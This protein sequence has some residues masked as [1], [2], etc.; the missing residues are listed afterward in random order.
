MAVLKRI[1]KVSFT[2]N[3]NIESTFTKYNSYVKIYNIAKENNIKIIPFDIYNFLKLHKEIEI[4]FDGMDISISFILNKIKDKYVIKV[5]K[6]Q[7]IQRQRF[8]LAYAFGIILLKDKT[9]VE[10]NNSIE[11]L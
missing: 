6:Y 5:N 10:E 1:L 9:L 8:S 4:T 7:N 11:I 3:S 2:N